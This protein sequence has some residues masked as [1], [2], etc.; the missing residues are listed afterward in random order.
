MIQQTYEVPEALLARCAGRTDLAQRVVNAF[1]AQLET[2]IPQLSH[3][4]SQGNF[5]EVSKLA[6][7]IKGAASNVD[8]E[9]IRAS[10]DQIELFAKSSETEDLSLE[11]EKLTLHWREYVE[12]TTSF[13]SS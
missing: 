10:A 12:L 11:L 8:A 7:R 6:H 9:A 13:L 4:L 5:E 3:E 1:V 2:D